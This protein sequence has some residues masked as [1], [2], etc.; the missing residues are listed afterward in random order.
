M[1]FHYV[2]FLANVEEKLR[3]RGFADDVRGLI[4]MGQDFDWS[5]ACG[6]VIDHFTFLGA[7]DDRDRRFL[8]LARVLLRKP[9][10]DAIIG[11]VAGIEHPIAWL[12]EG[13]PISDEAAALRQEDIQVYLAS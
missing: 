1:L 3:H 13:I 11:E 10:P 5:E 4:R 6:A 7:L 8:D 2:T 12:M 9:V